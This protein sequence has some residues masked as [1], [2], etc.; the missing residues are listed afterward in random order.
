MTINAFQMK[1]RCAAAVGLAAFALATPAAQAS[2]SASATI[3]DLRVQLIDLDMT[4]G[5]TPGITFGQGAGTPALLQVMTTVNG[6]SLNDHVYLPTGTAYGPLAVSNGGTYA[7]GTMLAGDPV[8]A[9]LV[10]PGASVES[11]ASG[12]NTMG[13]GIGYALPVDFTLTANTRMIVTTTVA[14]SV[15][16][17]LGDS[18]TAYGLLG[19]S[20]LNNN[21][22]ANAYIQS[23]I[24]ADGTQ[25]IDPSTALQI[26]FDNVGPNS[27]TG[28]LRATASAFS[29]SVTAVPEP[30]GAAMML[31]GL[32]LLAGAS[33]CRS[34]SR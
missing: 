25:L 5:I 14:T 34:Q 26:S 7:T 6:V 21:F 24:S 12:A 29:T 11:G 30:Q 3:A 27:Y 1:R 31:T 9:S 17:S 16:A 28:Y 22:F 23:G 32:V 19:G 10:G 2:A 4:D 8:G 33:R 20:D 13:W 18:A 15:H